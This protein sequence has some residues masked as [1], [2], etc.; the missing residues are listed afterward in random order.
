MKIRIVIP[1]WKR[2]EVTE[3]CFT[4]LLKVIKESKHEIC[5][6][7]V[8]SE[9]SYKKVCEDF[10][11]HWE[12]AENNPLGEKINTGIRESLY[13]QWD[14]LMTM[15]SDDVIDVKLI[16]E[17]YHPF[18]ESK[19]PYFGVNRVT[20]VNFA[21]KEARD[22]KYDYSV[23]GIAKCIRRDIVEQFKGDVYPPERNRGLDDG[24]MDRLMRSG[25]LPVMVDYP[26][27]MC[28]D[29]KSETNIWPWEHFKNK[30]IAV[31]YVTK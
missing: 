20:Y 1:L 16:D 10:G 15:N 24:L 11:F 22:F 21:T 12:W 8:I 28:W 19:I 18:F 27:Q 2:P 17:V 6:T 14:Y 31:E 26:G 7:C 23:L 3:F 4:E 5:V 30:G 25:V 13:F 29:F 9:E